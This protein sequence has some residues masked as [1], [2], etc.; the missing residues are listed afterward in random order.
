M[1]FSLFYLFYKFINYLLKYMFIQRP[2]KFPIKKQFVIFWWGSHQLILF[3]N[4]IRADAPRAYKERFKYTLWAVILRIYRK[5]VQIKL[6]Q[7]FVSRHHN[8]INCKF[9]FVTMHARSR[10]SCE[11]TNQFMVC[12]YICIIKKLDI[13]RHY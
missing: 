2:I 10:N 1:L 7:R 11:Q 3:N 6:A 8:T 5:F 9:L 4:N 13:W 12:P